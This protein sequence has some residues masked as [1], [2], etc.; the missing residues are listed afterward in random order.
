MSGLAYAIKF[1]AAAHED[2]VDKSG[3]PYIL[4]PLRIMMR[5]R[6]A[7]FAE[8]Y[9]IAAVLHDVVEDTPVTMEDIQAHFSKRVSLAVLA[10]TRLYPEG[11]PPTGAARQR[12]AQ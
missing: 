9:L 5:L 10:L 11:L 2:Q 3:A 4:H 6:E 8:A 1:A 12:A 7:G